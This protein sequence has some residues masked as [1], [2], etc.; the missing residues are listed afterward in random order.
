MKGIG[1]GCKDIAYSPGGVR[2]WVAEPDGYGQEQKVV[3]GQMDRL[4]A[5]KRR[6]G[7]VATCMLVFHL[8]F[9]ER[10]ED[11]YHSVMHAVQ[12]LGSSW[13][14]SSFSAVAKEQGVW[15]AVWLSWGGARSR[16]R[17]TAF[18]R[19]RRRCRRRAP[20]SHSHCCVTG[21][22][23]YWPSH[24][25]LRVGLRVVG[26]GAAAAGWPQLL[27]RRCAARRPCC[28]AWLHGGSRR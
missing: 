21:K 4:V 6:G 17:H 22:P 2:G 27:S 20:P 16:A 11:Q 7:S 19:R 1:R 13:L 12:S 9:P 23:F 5:T 14:A 26:R 8:S 24:A 15:G 10:D 3:W 25:G 28:G 18:R